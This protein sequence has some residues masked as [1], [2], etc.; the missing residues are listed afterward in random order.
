MIRLTYFL[1]F[2]NTPATIRYRFVIPYKVFNINDRGCACLHYLKYNTSKTIRKTI[3]IFICYTSWYY[4]SW[5]NIIGKIIKPSFI[6]NNLLYSCKIPYG[7]HP[8]EFPVFISCCCY[9][10]DFQLS[11]LFRSLAE[12]SF[13]IL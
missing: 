6:L 3:C 2:Y 4:Y 1:F 10:K 12:D 7:Y 13:Y 9:E 8:Y 5:V 11:S